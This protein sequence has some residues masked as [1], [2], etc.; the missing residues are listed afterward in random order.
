MKKYLI[1]KKMNIPLHAA[2]LPYL[3]ETIDNQ[4]VFLQV[5]SHAIKNAKREKEISKKLVIISRIKERILSYFINQI[6]EDKNAKQHNRS[7]KK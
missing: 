5:L 2:E 1:N 4:C 6:I 7:K 3:L